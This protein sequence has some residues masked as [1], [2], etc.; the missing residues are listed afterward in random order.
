MID[1]VSI[2]VRH[3]AESTRFYDAVLATLGHQRLVTR[4]HTVGY[5]KRYAELWLNSRPGRETAGDSG[6]HLCLRA[7]DRAAVEAFHSAALT[8]GGLDHGAPGFR[9]EYHEAYF[10]AFVRDRD[11]HVIEVVTFVAVEAD[12]AEGTQSEA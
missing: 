9:P 8:F 6:D 10:A 11:G 2:G 1:H 7:K 12:P 3:L 5:G 4:E